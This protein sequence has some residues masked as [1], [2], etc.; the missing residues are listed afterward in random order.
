[1]AVGV[2]LYVLG[3]S[4]WEARKTLS[5]NL[6]VLHFTINRGLAASKG[7]STD[8]FM[9]ICLVLSA[10]LEHLPGRMTFITQRLTAAPGL[11]VLLLPQSTLWTATENDPP[12]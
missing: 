8:L 10:L 4:Q 9:L 3:R 1:M 11:L 6:V 5:P 7:L 2:F 12:P